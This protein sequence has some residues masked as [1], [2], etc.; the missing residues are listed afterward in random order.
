MDIDL[1]IIL[2]EE[3]KG[4]YILLVKFQQNETGQQNSLN[5]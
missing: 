4:K 1:F 2:N 5:L 3:L